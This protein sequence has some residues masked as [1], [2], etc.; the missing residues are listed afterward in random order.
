MVSE[1]TRK[2]NL[3]EITEMNTI[4]MSP[5]M[6]KIQTEQLKYLKRDKAK[7]VADALET[8][9]SHGDLSENSE[10]TSAKDEQDKLNVDIAILED[11]L[12]RTVVVNKG[13][14]KSSDI[15]IGSKVKLFFVADKE[16][17]TYEICGI[18][19]SDP[20]KN[21]VSNESPYGKALMGK[22]KGD[23]ATIST[24]NGNIIVE[25][26]DVKQA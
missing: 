7:E 3:K 8:A 1:Y 20:L 21:K 11:Q 15:F 17:E 18:F 13:E 4:Y 5:E 16:E 10:Y 25:V 2:S 22:K 24:P 6:Y 23:K 12:S 14:R 19:E 9:R 26:R